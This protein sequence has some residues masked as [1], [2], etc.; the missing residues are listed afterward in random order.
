ME[1]QFCSQNGS[2]KFCFLW[3]VEPKIMHSCLDNEHAVHIARSENRTKCGKRSTCPV[4]GIITYITLSIW[5]LHQD[6]DSWE[7]RDISCNKSVC[8]AEERLSKAFLCQFFKW[9]RAPHHRPL[10]PGYHWFGDSGKDAAA[11]VTTISGWCFRSCWAQPAVQLHA[12]LPI[13]LRWLSP[14]ITGLNQ[15]KS[16]L[17]FWYGFGA[18]WVETWKYQCQYGQQFIL[19]NLLHNSLLLLRRA[20]RTASW[21]FFSCSLSIRSMFPFAVII[22]PECWYI[23]LLPL[24]LWSGR[25]IANKLLMVDK[26][27]TPKILRCNVKAAILFQ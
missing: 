10:L 23:L 19:S 20:L 14:K 6:I 4:T 8:P 22:E 11:E 5:L 2:S 21:I 25:S 9:S 16:K 24:Y 13:Q 18:A 17:I 15:R 3:L 12:K 26:E 7:P 1:A 27:K